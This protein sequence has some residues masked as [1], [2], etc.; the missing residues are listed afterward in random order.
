MFK[1]W[2]IFPFSMLIHMI[3]KT[4]FC[5]TNVLVTTTRT[6]NSIDNI[7]PLLM[8]NF[9]FYIAIKRK[10]L[11]V[12]NDYKFDMNLK[13][14]LIF[15]KQC[16]TNCSPLIPAYGKRK[17]ISVAFSFLFF[18]SFMDVLLEHFLLFDL[19]RCNNAFEI[20]TDFCSSMKQSFYPCCFY[21]QWSKCRKMNEL[22]EEDYLNSL[23]RIFDDPS[24]FKKIK[25]D[26]A[27]NRL[28]TVQKYLKRYLTEA[29]LLNWK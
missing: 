6:R 7:I 14:T 19:R 16:F 29:K 24:K 21:K 17:K 2:L 26:P 22:A 28:A 20:A 1:H 27:I 3:D 18:T 23:Q 11:S 25:Q 10:F 9:I 13:T 8:G 12:I 4:S 5:F 15:F